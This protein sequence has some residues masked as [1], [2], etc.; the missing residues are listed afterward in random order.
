MIVVV[1]ILGII[2]GIAVT[3]MGSAAARSRTSAVTSNVRIVQTKIDEYFATEGVFPEEPSGAWFVSGQLPPNPLAGGAN[4]VEIVT[5]GK[6]VTEPT[7]K[8]VTSGDKAYWYNRDNGM[9]RARVSKAKDATAALTAYNA[10]NDL[11][12]TEVTAV[13]LGP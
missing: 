13:S 8:T 9:F 5:A 6:T 12:L 4:T 3:R 11:K 7:E 1:V 2:S 10:V